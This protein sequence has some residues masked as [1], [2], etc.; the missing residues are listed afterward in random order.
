M[1][2]EDQGWQAGTA[3]MTLL[4]PSPPGAETRTALWDRSGWLWVR[5]AG[6]KVAWESQSRDWW[7]FSREHTKIW[8]FSFEKEVE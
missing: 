6:W 7:L 4:L 2:G 5:I 8:N 3:V 1:G